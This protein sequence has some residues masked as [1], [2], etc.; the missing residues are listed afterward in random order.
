MSA[1]VS[2]IFAVSQGFA[3]PTDAKR[4]ESFRKTLLEAF[5]VREL[6]A[7]PEYPKGCLE[8]KGTRKGDSVLFVPRLSKAARCAEAPAVEEKWMVTKPNK[9]FLAEE[10]G[11]VALESFLPVEEESHDG[12]GSSTEET[13]ENVVDVILAGG[14]GSMKKRSY[15]QP[16]SDE[17][18][19]DAF[20]AGTDHGRRRSRLS[21]DGGRASAIGGIGFGSG[22]RAGWESG[23]GGTR[24]GKMALGAGGTGNG[25]ATRAKI[26]APKSSDI[27]LSG[28]SGVRTPESILR[29]MRAHV[30]GFRYSFERFLRE[31]PSLG[32]TLVLKFTITPAGDI[33]AISVV[34]SNTG[35]A[36]LDDEINGKARRMKFDQIEKGV[37]TVTYSLVLQK[38]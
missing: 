20:V 5:R 34:S 19:S 32:G 2:L 36:S 21:E 4:V 16:D 6:Y 30:G 23:E 26:E 24:Q 31:D 14:G 35:N 25:I 1:L 38:Q 13:Q 7:A 8:W 37:V 10:D 11:R 9:V 29:V 17:E 12:T 28:D 15:S 27:T 3:A 22:G 33:V 18:H